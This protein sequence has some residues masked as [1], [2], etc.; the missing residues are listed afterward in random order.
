MSVISD[1]DGAAQVTGV[2]AGSEED[3]GRNDGKSPIPSCSLDHHVDLADRSDVRAR[4]ARLKLAEVEEEVLFEL[5]RLELERRVNRAKREAEISELGAWPQPKYELEPTTIVQGGVYVNRDRPEIPDKGLPARE[6]PSVADILYRL[7]LPKLDLPSY[8]GDPGGYWNFIRQFEV[9]VESRVADNQLRLSYLSRCCNGR[10]KRIIEGC[11]MLPADE[12]YSTAKTT[13]AEVFGQPFIVTKA[14]IDQLVCGKPIDSSADE[15]ME[16]SIQMQNCQ[17]ALAQLNREGELSSVTNMEG[18][19]RR[20]PSE[21]QRDWVEY[22]S[23]LCDRNHEP[24]FKDLQLFVKRRARIANSMYSHLLGHS[25][26]ASRV[27]VDRERN[28]NPTFSPRIVCCACGASHHL[29]ECGM[30]IGMS[31]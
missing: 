23:D 13:L 2:A 30:F 29:A 16:F 28:S 20:L 31:A 7:D 14:L 26:G 11:A 27:A 15:L 8:N 1:G 10:A 18:V 5:R 17:L 12:G 19:I 21:L 3:L 24:T 9:Q 25:Y 22:A 6:Q 4:L